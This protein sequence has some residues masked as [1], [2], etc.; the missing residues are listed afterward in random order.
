MACLGGENYDCVNDGRIKTSDTK[1]LKI[2]KFNREAAIL[3]KHIVVNVLAYR[4]MKTADTISN[5]V[6]NLRHLKNCKV[7]LTPYI[8][9]NHIRL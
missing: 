1:I 4:T 9:L 6:K 2:I 3:N 8:N 7:I 5:I